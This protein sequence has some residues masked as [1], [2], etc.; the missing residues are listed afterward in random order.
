M[1][2]SGRSTRKKESRAIKRME[3]T[4]RGGRERRPGVISE[5]FRSRVKV[6][7]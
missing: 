1:G 3:M 2:L 4:E 6:E 7:T 5:V